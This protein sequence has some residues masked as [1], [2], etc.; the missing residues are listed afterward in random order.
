MENIKFKERKAFNFY[1]SYYETSL[2]LDGKDKA[3]FLECI[4]NYQFTG[5]LI[6]PKR[7]NSLLA[8][9]GQ[10]HSINKQIIGFDKGK[11]TY[12][13]GYP[14]KGKDKGKGKGSH[15][16]VQEEEQVQDEVEEKEGKEL[17]LLKKET[18]EENLSKENP[19]EIF[20][21]CESV[22]TGAEE[23]KKVAPKKE[24]SEEK[25]I[26]PDEFI[27]I[28]E[29]WKEYRK[30]KRFKSY[31]GLKWE[32]MAV[33]KLL[34]LSDKNPTIAKLILKQTY[35]NSYQGFFPLKQN[36]NG[37]TNTTN[38]GFS[39][40]KPSTNNGN[41][42]KRTYRQILAERLTNELKANGEGSNITIDAEIC[43]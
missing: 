16:E 13:N 34:E 26:M 9:R 6:E 23:R 18:K 22:E 29:E 15:K 17:F 12:P 5:I 30:A 32:Q 1:R 2:L 10:I 14:T 20:P 8:F 3:E 42:G 40:S 35:E 41:S 28:W 24:R 11:D 43:E 25:P 7:K 38:T 39:T 19:T 27:E 21:Q 37:I 33:D 36:T 4:I 31:A